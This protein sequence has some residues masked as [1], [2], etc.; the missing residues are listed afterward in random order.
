MVAGAPALEDA[1][2]LAQIDRTCPGMARARVEIIKDR[3]RSRVLPGISAI[4]AF[5]PRLAHGALPCA[6]LVA[7]QGLGLLW[8]TVLGALQ[9]LLAAGGL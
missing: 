7:W 3:P 9:R 1:G 2:R 6:P 8:G 4:I 5:R